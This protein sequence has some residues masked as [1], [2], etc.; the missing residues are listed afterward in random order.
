MVD[1]YRTAAPFAAGAGAC[2]IV[3]QI[4]QRVPLSNDFL[5][6]AVSA[7]AAYAVAWCVV[8]LFPNGR[9][10]MADSVRLMRTE[11]PRLLNRRRSAS[12]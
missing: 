3:L 12:N 9:A 7:I 8:A 6:L 5:H 2:F 11:L 10:A 4:V 1:L